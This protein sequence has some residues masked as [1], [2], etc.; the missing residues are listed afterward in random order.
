M[1][2]DVCVLYRAFIEKSI[3]PYSVKR[4]QKQSYVFCKLCNT[5]LESSPCMKVVGCIS[6]VPVICTPYSSLINL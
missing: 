5:N 6:I 1:A 2:P 4:D 3:S